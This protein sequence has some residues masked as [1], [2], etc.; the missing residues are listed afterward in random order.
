MVIFPWY[1]A[2]WHEPRASPFLALTRDCTLRARWLRGPF[3]APG[4]RGPPLLDTPSDEIGE[5]CHAALPILSQAAV[6][7]ALHRT[8]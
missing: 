6:W 3:R 2:T 1:S 7:R 4:P 8:V 5:R